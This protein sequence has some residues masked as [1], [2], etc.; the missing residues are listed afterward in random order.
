MVSETG[1]VE[2]L[3]HVLFA[4]VTR[5]TLLMSAFSPLGMEVHQGQPAESS[6]CLSQSSCEKNHHENVPTLAN[7]QKKKKNTKQPWP[8]RS[9]P[10]LWLASGRH[11]AFT[12][13]KNVQELGCKV[14]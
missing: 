11:P 9:L 13:E 5:D 12:H 6:S 1:S 4:A 2:S 14:T 8:L 7:C 10:L 3:C